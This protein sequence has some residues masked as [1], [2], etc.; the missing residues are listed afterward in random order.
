MSQAPQSTSQEI[1]VAT[2]VLFATT[3]LASASYLAQEGLSN[4][5]QKKDDRPE[6]EVSASPEA[7]P[8]KITLDQLRQ[9]VDEKSAVIVDARKPEQ[10]QTGHIP[11][12]INLPAT[13]PERPLPAQLQERAKFQ[14][15]IVYCQSET[16]PYAERVAER[17]QQEGV[18]P[19][20][21]FEGGW[22]KWQ[23]R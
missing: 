16:C 1:A 7:G 4:D 18:T 19:V 5:A 12:A 22:Q 2:V 20:Q 6:F 10:Y 21:V 8:A 11:G 14:P 23:R 9:H 15:V 3:L 13:Q 17:L